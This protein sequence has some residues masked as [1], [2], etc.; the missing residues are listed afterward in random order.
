MGI[1]L[2]LL[3]IEVSNPPKGGLK[4]INTVVTGAFEDIRRVGGLK[5]P[6]PLE[7]ESV[8]VIRRRAGGLKGYRE[9]QFL[10]FPDIRR[11]GGLEG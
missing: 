2:Y 3:T 1:R 7:P 10:T 5:G 8:M 4:V 6:P 9:R 11:A